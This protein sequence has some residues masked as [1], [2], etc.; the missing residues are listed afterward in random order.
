VTDSTVIPFPA[1]EP[2]PEAYRQ[3]DDP[4]VD[5]EDSKPMAG[6]VVYTPSANERFWRALGFR[7]QEGPPL[8]AWNADSREDLQ[9][10]AMTH[11]NVHLSGLD[12]LRLLLTGRLHLT[13]RHVSSKPIV[14][15]RSTTDFRI[16]YPGE[17]R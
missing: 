9:G 14:D 6:C 5:I 15:L 1:V 10:W 16:G 3:P 4:G 11:V 7:T 17:R 13:V 12:R 2:R 8:E